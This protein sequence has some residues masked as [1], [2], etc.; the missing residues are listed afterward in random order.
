MGELFNYMGIQTQDQ[1]SDLMAAAMEN[2][3]P[4]GPPTY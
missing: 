4:P 3:G 2:F 1:F